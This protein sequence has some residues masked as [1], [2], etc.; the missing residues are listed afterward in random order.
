MVDG[1]LA[2]D[3]RVHLREEARRQLD[4]GHAA[5]IGRRNEAREV[6]DHAAAECNDRRSAVKPQL[7]RAR[8]EAVC[9]REAL[10]GLACGNRDDLRPHPCAF[11]HLRNMRGAER[12]DI[13]I[14]DDHTARR[15]PCLT[16]ECDDLIVNGIP[17]QNGVAALPKLDCHSAYHV[18]FSISEVPAGCALP[19]RAASGLPYRL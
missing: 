12:A 14:R 15:V 18:I 11:E 3:A 2:A 10:R 4:K 17:D 7:D 5:H 1:D 6:T 9:L 13:R 19:P 8:E 16:H